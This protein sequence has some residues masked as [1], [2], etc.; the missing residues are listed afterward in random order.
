[1][2]SF[3]EVICFTSM[4]W[5]ERREREIVFQSDSIPVWNRA[6]S[7]QPPANRIMVPQDSLMLSSRSR[8]LSPF[9]Y[10]KTAIP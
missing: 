5:L 10:L 2:E 4:V 8:S 3:Y 6:V 9:S 1:M 7:Q